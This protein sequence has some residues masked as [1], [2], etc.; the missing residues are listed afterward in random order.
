MLT[1]RVFDPKIFDQPGICEVVEFE[2]HQDW[3][4]LFETLVPIVHESKIK[5]FLFIIK[6]VEDD[7][8]LTNMV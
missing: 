5:D 1:G 2:R 3:V 4:Y 8:R 6:F 7:L